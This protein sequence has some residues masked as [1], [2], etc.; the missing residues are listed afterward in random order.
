M[1]YTSKK[2]NTF[3]LDRKLKGKKVILKNIL[4]EVD[5]FSL[6]PSSYFE[7]RRLANHLKKKKKTKI[8][9]AG[10]TDNTGSEE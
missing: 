10:H 6:N 1:N 3:F 8:K 5:D 7:I 4:Y 9:I 2:N